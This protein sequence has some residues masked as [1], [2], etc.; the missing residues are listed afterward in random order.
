MN[1]PTILDGGNI[2]L[3]CG[4]CLDILPTLEPG[5][6]D[7]FVMD[8]P[9]PREFMPLFGQVAEHAKRLLPIGRHLVSLC[10]HYEVADVLADMTKYLRWFWLGAVSH[11]TCACVWHYHLRAN[12]KPVLWFTNGEPDIRWEG[13]MPDA[14]RP[15]GPDKTYHVWGQPAEWARHWIARITKPDELVCDP[16]LGGGSTGVACIL[17]GRRF[18]GIENNRESF[19]KAVA[20]IQTELDAR[21]GQGPLM[22]AA[23]LIE[24]PER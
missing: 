9:Y 22:R 23:K 2:V 14:V 8:P 20:H 18:I 10:G 12:F 24:E 21:D 7:A 1:D 17:E 5:S 6:V 15:P 3:Y 11:H 13:G 19:D 16:F 4:D